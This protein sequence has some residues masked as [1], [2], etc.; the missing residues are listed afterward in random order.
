[1]RNLFHAEFVFLLLLKLIVEDLSYAEFET[2]V[3][4]RTLVRKM[5]NRTKPGIDYDL[6]NV[7]S[8]FLKCLSKCF[9]FFFLLCFTS[10]AWAIKVN[11]NLK[12][13]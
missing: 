7:F 3:R 9:I 10:K 12:N 4:M 2:L 11:Q 6:E 8:F 13:K 5:E 1:M